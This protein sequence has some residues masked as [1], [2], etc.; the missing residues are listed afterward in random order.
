MLLNWLCGAAY[1]SIVLFVVL[2]LLPTGALL[3]LASLPFAIKLC[4]YVGQYYN[5]PQAVSSCKFIAVAMH[6][7]SG[8]LFGPWLSGDMTYTLHLKPYHRPFQK[9]LE[10][11]HGVWSIRN[12]LLVGLQQGD[13]IGWGEVAPLPWFGTETLEEANQLL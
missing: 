4:R 5:Q 1:G 9:P 3:S 8:L 11:A 6:F 10:T 12:G 2:K 13:A 7:W